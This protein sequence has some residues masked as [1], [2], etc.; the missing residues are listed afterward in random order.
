MKQAS[1]TTTRIT[2]KVEQAAKR[3]KLEQARERR[4]LREKD[5]GKLPLFGARR[6]PVQRRSGLEIS[7]KRETVTQ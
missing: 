1:A 4:E 2:E 7:A 3:Q 5:R 6:E